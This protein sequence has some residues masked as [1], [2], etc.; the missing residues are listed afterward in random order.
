MHNGIMIPDAPSNPRELL[1]SVPRGVY[2][3][4][5]VHPDKGV[6]D[7]SLHHQRIRHN[8]LAQP[9]GSAL[10]DLLHGLCDRSIGIVHSH[11]HNI[12]S[13]TTGFDKKHAPVSI[14]TAC[15]AA[16][17]TQPDPT[18]LVLF[19]QLYTDDEACFVGMF[20]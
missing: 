19:L 16:W 2:T 12:P 6:A 20:L 18:D 13:T 1:A 5:L 9:Q 4:T 14:R 8:A 15:E 11:H 7:W 10:S 3:T 17:N